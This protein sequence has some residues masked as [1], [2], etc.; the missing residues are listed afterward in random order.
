[1]SE[2]TDAIRLA[3]KLLDVP[4]AD[5]DDDLRLLARQLL[6]HVEAVEKL[7][8]DLTAQLDPMRDVIT[9]NRDTILNMHQE[10]VRRVRRLL[11]SNYPGRRDLALEVLDALSLFHPMHDWKGWPKGGHHDA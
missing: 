7:K 6:R 9:T 4:N 10:A 1:M 5:P 11:E 3:N 2:R 8:A